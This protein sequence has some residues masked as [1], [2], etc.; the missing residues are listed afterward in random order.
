MSPVLL[1]VWSDYA[2]PFCY[3]EEPDLHRVSGEFVGLIEVVW[4]PFE[5]RPDPVDIPDPQG[6]YLRSVWPSQVLPMALDRGMSLRL[7]PFQPRSRL[8]HEAACQARMEGAFDIMNRAIFRALFEQGRDIGQEEVLLDLARDCGLN[9]GRMAAALRDG[10][11]TQKVIDGQRE[12]EAAGIS[13]VPTLII[14]HGVMHR[15]DGVWLEGVVPYAQLQAAVQ[16]V[17]GKPA[18]GVMG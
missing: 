17:A 16:D 12:A 3:L 4:H 18:A 14:H 9:T 6:D 1:E 10:T 8:A 11:H 5:L 7:P 13:A 15:N 2:C